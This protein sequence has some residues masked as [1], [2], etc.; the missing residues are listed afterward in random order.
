MSTIWCDIAMYSHASIN[1]SYG[2]VNSMLSCGNYK[3]TCC[4]NLRFFF[5]LCS[6]ICHVHIWQHCLVMFC[7]FPLEQHMLYVCLCVGVCVSV[8]LSVCVSVCLCVSVCV[9]VCLCVSVY[10]CLCMLRCVQELEET[11]LVFSSSSWL[12]SEPAPPSLHSPP[13]P[14]RWSP[15][16]WFRPLTYKRSRVRGCF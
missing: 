16:W 15:V 8:C 5:A 11:Y 1:V 14:Q 10:V 12:R 7:S 4:H 9:C 3:A 6:A 2:S 13:L